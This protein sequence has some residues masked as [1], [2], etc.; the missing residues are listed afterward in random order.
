MH[1][2]QDD[3]SADMKAEDIYVPTE[4]LEGAGEGWGRTVDLYLG[5]ATELESA[6]RLT[7]Q[8]STVLVVRSF[9]YFTNF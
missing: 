7:H 3:D 4:R 9:I 1:P 2:I 6:W 8:T 5:C